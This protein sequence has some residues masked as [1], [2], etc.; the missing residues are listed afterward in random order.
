MF[1]KSLVLIF[2]QR[3]WQALGGT[4]TFFFIVL[5]LSSDQQGWFYT[6]LSIASLYTLLEM[7]LSMALIQVSSH[8]FIKLKW[9]PDGSVNGQNAEIFKSFFSCSMKVYIRFAFLFLALAIVIGYFIFKQKSGFIV[10]GRIWLWP[11]IALL[12]GTALNMVMLPFFA[13]AEGSGEVS[14]VYT[15]RL[16][17][18]LIGSLACWFVLWNGGDLWAACMAPILGAAISFFWFFKKKPWLFKLILWPKLSK[19]FDWS[20]EVW[21]LQ[22]RIAISWISIYLM[23][24]LCVPILFYFKNP[25]IAGQM[26]VSLS[27]VH[28][29]GLLSQS[30][31]TR[32]IAMMSK[33]AAGK[34]WHILDDLFK[35][36]FLRSM[37]VFI[38]GAVI[39]L[40]LQKFIAQS[41]YANRIFSFWPFLGLL[42]FSFFY[43]MNIALAIQLRSYRKEPLVWAFLLGGILILIATAIAAKNYSV[44]EVILVMVMTQILFISPLSIYIWQNRNRQYRL[45]M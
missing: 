20:K 32:R 28:M 21:P 19:H 38:F 10:E 24:Q 36:D 9:L 45:E 44:N 8:L 42:I 15:L 18:G 43:Y 22:W 17:Q 29:L 26:G 3:L 23:T 37:S 35:K 30:W 31:I 34:E 12:V 33:A 2:M 16:L 4:L 39:L 6:F 41:L 7:G 11:W 5:T 1:T 25:L 13:V 14:E 40:I 27:I